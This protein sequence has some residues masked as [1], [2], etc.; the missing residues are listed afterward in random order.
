MQE[1][2]KYVCNGREPRSR[3]DLCLD[4]VLISLLTITAP[5]LTKMDFVEDSLITTFQIDILS[6]SDLILILKIHL[7]DLNL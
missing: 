7:K 4:L 5:I 2:P 3:L 6:R 1:F